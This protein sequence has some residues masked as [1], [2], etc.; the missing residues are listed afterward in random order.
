[1]IDFNNVQVPNRLVTRLTKWNKIVGKQMII[2]G[3][4]P[5]LTSPIAPLLL[6]QMKQPRQ[7]KGNLIQEQEY[8][9]QLNEE[10][11]N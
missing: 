6:Q 4:Q 11:K 5:E 10:L 1:M 3:A 2:N 8:Q 9:T 7:F